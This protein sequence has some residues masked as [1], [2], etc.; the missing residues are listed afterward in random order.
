MNVRSAETADRFFWLKSGR[1][2]DHGPVRYSLHP[3]LPVYFFTEL[4]DTGYVSGKTFFRTRYSFLPGYQRLETHF[5]FR[6][7]A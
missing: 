1:A 7:T 5:E 3:R 2:S 4:K 6:F